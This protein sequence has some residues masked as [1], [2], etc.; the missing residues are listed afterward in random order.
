MTKSL[1]NDAYEE[2]ADVY[3][4]LTDRKPHNAYYERP[5]TQSLIDDVAGKTILDAGCGPGAMT[6]WLLD[7]GAEVVGI[8]A[9]EKM[10]THARS[11]NG[12]G[13]TFY[14]LNLEEPL[15]ILKDDS[16][17]GIVCS[18]AITYVRDHSVLFAE[19]S[20]AL[21][22]N[23]W[24]V[25]STEHPFFSYGYFKLEDYFETQQVSCDWTGFGKT[26]RMPSYY[27]SLGTICGALSVNHFTI[28]NIVEPKPTEEFKEADL[29]NY[30]KLIKFPLFICI[31]ARKS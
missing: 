23:G 12:K 30:N 19:F 11:R 14:Q 6:K 22:S 1:P 5:A 10:L 17:D 20:R 7:R 26:V 8:D 31:K 13:A 9:N 25:F 27:H 4:S 29:E 16:F 28:Q 18:L 3:A 2:L 21:K 15:E 24:L